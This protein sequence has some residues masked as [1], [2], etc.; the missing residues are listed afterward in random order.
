MIANRNT[1]FVAFQIFG[2]FQISKIDWVPN[3][4]RLGAKCRSIAMMSGLIHR[5]TAK[6]HPPTIFLFK[7]STLSSLGAAMS[8]ASISVTKS[9]TGSLT[10]SP[11]PEIIV[12]FVCGHD[13]NPVLSGSRRKGTWY[14]PIPK[15]P[16]TGRPPTLTI[17]IDRRYI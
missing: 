12:K 9:A 6:V 3:V 1:I 11:R 4:D 13:P 17:R 5:P 7:P 10:W 15:I 2:Y 8:I 16:T 14:L